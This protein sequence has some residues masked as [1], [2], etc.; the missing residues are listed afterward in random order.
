MGARPPKS[1]GRTPGTRRET[2]IHPAN[3]ADLPTVLDAGQAGD[4]LRIS[5]EAV[6]RLANE[7]QLQR[8]A[9]AKRDFLF[10]AEEVVR[11][12]AEQSRP[13]REERP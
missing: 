11:F 13:T 5:R 7:G 8:L 9:Y 12:L 3:L 10:Y 2:R 6:C 1:S 4:V